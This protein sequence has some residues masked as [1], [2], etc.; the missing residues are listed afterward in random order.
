MH[1]PASVHDGSWVAIEARRA[2]TLDAA[3]Q[4]HPGRFHRRPR[5]RQMPAQAWINQPPATIQAT[6]SPQIT[7]AA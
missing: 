2:A 6:P 4:A 7:Q 3:Y 1:T 5:P